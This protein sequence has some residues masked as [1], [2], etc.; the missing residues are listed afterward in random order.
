MTS[1]KLAFLIAALY[2]VIGF[3]IAF[4]MVLWD[5]AKND[6]DGVDFYYLIIALWPMVIFIVI[7]MIPSYFFEKLM[8]LLNDAVNGRNEDGS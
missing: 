2:F 3:I 7:L 5:I 4:G 6:Y 1:N 8:N